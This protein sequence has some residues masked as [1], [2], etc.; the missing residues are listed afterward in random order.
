[1]RHRFF[2]LPMSAVSVSDA[3]LDVR[4]PALVVSGLCKSYGA[5]H[6]LSGMDF[7][8]P[9]GQWWVLLGPNGA[10]KSTLIQLLCGLFAPDAGH[11]HI[12]GHDLTR[13]PSAALAQLGVVFQ[14]STLDLDLSVAQNLAYHAA[15]HGLPQGLVRER[16]QALLAWM[17]LSD[18][19]QRRVRELSGGNRRKV[20]LVRAL[21]HG[22]RVLLMDE[23]TV[24]LDPAS[25]DHLLTSVAELVREQQVSVLWTTHWVQEARHADALLVMQ[26]GRLLFHNTPA[27]LLTHTGQSDWET[28]FL[29]LTRLPVAA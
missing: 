15:L 25:R 11:I 7:V 26:R 29:Q 23:A 20:E 13:Q 21:L 28:A 22:P 17:G 14:Q 19:A 3:S 1:M 18:Q 16:Q 9:T 2:L 6:A 27:E 8:L 4:N 10:G 12:G 24:G 5:V